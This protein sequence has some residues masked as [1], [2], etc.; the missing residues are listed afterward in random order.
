M[1]V[2]MNV[3]KCIWVLA[4]VLGTGVTASTMQAASPQSRQDQDHAQDYSTNRNYNVGVRDGKYDKQRNKDH[5]RKRH[6]NNDEDR[7][8]YEYGYQHG[9]QDD[10]K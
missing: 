10:Q 7:K 5:S 9:H 3:R 1:R 2:R 8:A 6:F 4:L